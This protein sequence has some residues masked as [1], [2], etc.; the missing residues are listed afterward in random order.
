MT[1]QKMGEFANVSPIPANHTAKRLSNVDAFGFINAKS[2]SGSEGRDP[3]KL[4]LDKQNFLNVASFFG[5][6]NADFTGFLEDVDPTFIPTNQ[7][8]TAN[9]I[10]RL[11][12]NQVSRLTS[13]PGEKDVIPKSPDIDDQFGAK[14]AGDILSHFHDL[15][16]RDH[17]RMTLAFW[18][19]V[20]GDAFEIAEWDYDGG[21]MLE[22]ATNPFDPSTKIDLAKANPE[23]REFLQSMGTIKKTRAG[24]INIDY[25]SPFQVSVPRGARRLED[26]NWCMIERERSVDWIWDHFPKVGRK[27]DTPDLDSSL[28]GH[29]WT[30]I[31]SMINRIGFFTAPTQSS[32]TNDTILVRELI[33][34]PSGRYPNGFHISA[35]KTQLLFNRPHPMIEMG[36]DPHDRELRF[37]RLP[38]SH[39]QY[40]PVPG[41]MWGQGM[42]EHLIAPQ[43]DYNRARHQVGQQRDVL[44]QPQWLMSKESGLT[45]TRNNYGD[46]WEYE[47]SGG[48]PELQQ[49]PA[50][51]QIHMA[52]MDLAISDM[53]QISS[54]SD[55]SQG[56]VPTGM[57]SGVAIR[58]LQ[59][60]DS[61]SLTPSVGSMEAASILTDQRV[62]VLVHQK[63]PGEHMVRVYGN[64]RQADIQIF[65]GSQING[66]VFVRIKAGSMM[67]R[68]KV[69]TME[70][71]GNMV[72]MGVMDPMN[73]EH[74]EQ[75][76]NAFEYGG[77]DK[78][79][80]VRHA[81]ERR[82]EIENHMFWKPK[83]DQQTGTPAPFPAI[84][85][86]DDHDVHLRKHIEFLKTDTFQVL[87][88]IRQQAF[89]AHMLA[90]KQ[91]I[92]QNIM[93]QQML[94]GG[95]PGA[96]GPAGPGGGGSPP[97]QKGEAS[98]PAEKQ[99]TP[100]SQEV[101]A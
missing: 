33:V 82:A 7:T 75:I 40:A 89:R 31:N 25:L 24:E 5:L 80:Q 11:V 19:C 36:L 73:P 62:L 45:Q 50:M 58:F 84:D 14:V 22:Q 69:E 100:G 8:Y 72:Q 91:A 60:Q 95:A 59:E 18:M 87:P 78:M 13:A 12:M 41:R 57:R 46:F 98:Q 47:M 30:R 53:Q 92:M 23:E 83:M 77:A 88:P 81:D 79:F 51:S 99:P 9:R 55:A 32:D 43:I 34:P 49:P 65:K 10:F 48:K 97:A 67:P 44:A 39:Y 6:Q 37:M 63:M 70:L 76:L 54:Q 1:D 29:Y 16:Q 96:P 26:A 15:Y 20:C 85:D 90:H 3:M 4:S 66:N 93:T 38:V 64:S 42:V 94:V 28:E 68:S 71:M 61:R 52:S 86:D 27:L 74:L 21:K 101:K 17:I 56:S 2:A 35:T